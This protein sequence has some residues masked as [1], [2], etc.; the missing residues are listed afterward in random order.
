MS[1]ETK[2][3]VHIPAARL[4]LATQETI[5][6]TIGTPGIKFSQ[7]NGTQSV[8]KITL[9]FSSI[10]NFVADSETPV[11]DPIKEKFRD[12]VIDVK[13]FFQPG[14][15]TVTFTDKGDS[16]KM[17]IEATLDTKI[18]GTGALLPLN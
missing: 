14:N 6:G 3:L 12:A 9:G 2:Q 16:V 18:P 7:S 1:K 10:A 4:Q 13:E 5:N 17:T 15:V 11:D 8:I